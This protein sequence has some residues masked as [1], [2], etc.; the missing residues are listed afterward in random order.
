VDHS[1]NGI[2]SSWADAKA[3]L[4][5]G[6][7]LASHCPN[8]TQVW[9]AKGVYTPGINRT[10][11]FGLV[12]GVAL[13]GGFDPAGGADEFGERDWQAYPTILSG[14]IGGDDIHTDGVVM[15]TTHIVGGNSFHVILNHGPGVSITETTVLDGFTITAGQAQACIYHNDG[16]GLHCYGTG[17]GD[18]CGPTLHNVH[19]SGNMADDGGGMSAVT[20]NGS[21]SPTLENVSFRGNA[22][23]ERGGGMVVQCGDDTNSPILTNVTFTG[24]SGEEGGALNVMVSNDCIMNLTLTD[25][26][27]TGNHAEHGGALYLLNWKSDSSQTLTNVTFRGNTAEERGGALYSTNWI[28]NISETLTNVVFAGNT[29]N[30]GGALYTSSNEG[31]LTTP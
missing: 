4:A 28:G 31:D 25:V 17:S 13:Y 24:N 3:D 10:D 15:T 2:G 5:L 16:G 26:T 7:E 6:L 22:A 29:A 19:F 27:F 18:E 11:S 12:S 8:I 1:A 20:N 23:E 21:S 9:V 14:D 30:E